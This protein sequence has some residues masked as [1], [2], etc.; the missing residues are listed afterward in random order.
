[1]SRTRLAGIALG[2]IFRSSKRPPDFTPEQI[3][4]AAPEQVF[5]PGFL[6]GAATSA[7]QVEGGNENDWTDWERSTF[8]DGT[9][10]I[11]DRTESGLACDSYR[12]FD[13]DLRLLKELGANAYRLGVEWARLEPSEGAWNQEAADRYRSWLDQLAAAGIR[14]MVTVHHFTLPRWVSADGGWQTDRTIDRLEAFTRKVA[15]AFGARVDLWCT[16]NE[17]NVVGIHGYLKGIWPPG[18]KDEVQ[19]AWAIAR[20]MKAHARMARVLREK[21]GKPV[22]IAHHV[23]VFQPATRSPMDKVVARVA[24]DFFNDSLV[25]CHRTGRIRLMVPG[26]VDIDE[27][28]PDLKGSYDYLGI[29]YYSRDHMKADF[30]EPSMS[31]QFVPE[32]RPV[33]DLGW[34]IYPEGLYLLLRRYGRLKIPIHITENGISD[35]SGAL[36]AD[37]LRSHLYA[38]EAALRDGVDVRGYFHWSLMDNFEWAEGLRS[39]F[40]LYRVD[41][42]DPRR[43]RTATP[44]VATFQE[45]ARK[46][47]RAPAVEGKRSWGS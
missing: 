29:N 32:G 28:V 31:R 14:S 41:Y 35:E 16:L 5:P 9:P 45:F 46:L 38:V 26:K 11:H 10:H 12:R 21:T 37:F 13:E 43:T 19:C 22:G 44:A 24:E 40:G 7:H 6:L 25:D 3:A 15:E 36:R 17:P 33:S 39:R 42:T 20:Q 18:L 34:D 47:A 1:M 2:S 23:R 27:A 30:K 8:P 4:R